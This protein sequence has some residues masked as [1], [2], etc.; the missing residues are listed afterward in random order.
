[1]SE[2]PYDYKIKFGEIN[3]SKDAQRKSGI[4]GVDRKIVHQIEGCVILFICSYA[5][6]LL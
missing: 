5:I 4:V 6:L 2:Q 1:M 3:K